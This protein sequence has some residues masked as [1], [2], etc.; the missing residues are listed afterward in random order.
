[1]GTEDKKRIAIGVAAIVLASCLM[2]FADDT[3][4]L[5]PMPVHNFAA[6]LFVSWGYLLLLPAVFVMTYWQFGGRDHARV[7]VLCVTVVIALLDTY[8][9]ATQWAMGL[10]H[11]GRA[12][13]LAVAIENALVFAGVLGLATAGVLRRSNALSAYAYI[14]V[15]MA[16]GWCAFPLLGRVS[17]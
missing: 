15:F 5:I 1:M 10:E 9:I 3:T 4:P 2:P 8:W 16:L 17:P 12:F 14:G 13:L 6:Y 7:L 11:P